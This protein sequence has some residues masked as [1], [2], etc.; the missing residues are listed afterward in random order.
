MTNIPDGLK[1]S[2]RKASAADAARSESEEAADSIPVPL[3]SSVRGLVRLAGGVSAL[4]IAG[5]LVLLASLPLLT[6]LYTP[7]EFG[8]FTI[9]LAAVNIL[10]AAAALRF[11][12]SLYVV[13]NRAQARVGLKLILFSLLAT[14]SLVLAAGLVTVDRLPAETHNLVF[15]VPLGL[16]TAGL[17][18]AINCWALRFGRLRDFALGRLMLP[19]FMAALQVAFGLAQLGGDTMVVAHILSQILFAGVLGFRVF[20]RADFRGVAEASWR[21]AARAARREYKFP[22]YDLPATVAGYAIINLPAVLIGS[23]FGTTLAGHFGVAARLVTGP[24]TLMATPLS[25]VFVAEAGKSADGA[26]LRR[27]GHGL[28]LVAA[29]AIAVPVLGLGLVAP[30]LVVPVLG[31]PWREAGHIVTA[32]AVMAAFQVLSTPLQDVPTLMRR[33]EV[34]LGVDA[35]RALLVFGPLLLGFH[36]GWNALSV[37]DLMAAGGA[38]GFALRAGASLLLLNAMSSAEPLPNEMRPSP[39][40]AARCHG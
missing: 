8:L 28:L 33:Q 6:R 18:E 35:V 12:T 27:S 29:G 38:A 4:S 32:L 23:L 37:I 17:V 34:R 15:L 10:G 24:T 13:E 20:S 16:A 30:Y 9:Y 40:D 5:Q 25:N 7:A 3:G 22:L 11:E 19:S 21:D 31:E 26:H 39:P 14:G 36:A 2:L 1:F